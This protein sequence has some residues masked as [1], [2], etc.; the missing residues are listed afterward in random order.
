MIRADWEY[1]ITAPVSLRDHPPKYNLFYPWG[2]IFQHSQEW[3]KHDIQL[4]GPDGFLLDMD[5]RNDEYTYV[6][7]MSGQ[8]VYKYITPVVPTIEYH[9]F[10]F[11]SMG[12]Q[13]ILEIRMVRIYE[14]D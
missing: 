1:R 4:N 8:S 6:T 2:I 13:Y 14:E 5:A 12:F 7:D 9:E 3:Q 10:K 11:W